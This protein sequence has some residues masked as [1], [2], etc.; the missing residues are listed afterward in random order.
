MNSKFVML[1]DKV[2]FGLLNN[3]EFLEKFP[4]IKAALEAAKNK[5]ASMVVKQG[6]KPCQLRS[7]QM[8]IDLMSVKKAIARF[9]DEDKAKMKEFMKTDQIRIIFRSEDNKI[10]KIEF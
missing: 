5:A 7:R 8:S 10:T 1:D 3:E 6:C 9:S 4:N 2:T